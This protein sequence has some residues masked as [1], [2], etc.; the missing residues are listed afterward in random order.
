[1]VK[2]AII[3]AVSPF[4]LGLVLLAEAWLENSAIGWKM[5]KEKSK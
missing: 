2:A 4:L 5:H 1:M 3:I